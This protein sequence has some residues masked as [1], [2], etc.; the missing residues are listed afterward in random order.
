M[1]KRATS[2]L[3][4][5][6]SPVT[7]DNLHEWTA[8]LDRAVDKFADATANLSITLAKHSQR[9]DSG[10]KMIE[11]IQADHLRLE[12]KMDVNQKDMQSRLD[13]Q[14]ESVKAHFDETIKPLAKKVNVLNRWRWMIMGAITFIGTIAGILTW[15][16]E[17]L[18]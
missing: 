3:D 2:K 7:H 13:A 12:T 15:V 6:L 11:A 17:L 10:D 1:A 8:R 16:H 9:L 18:K 14:T 4:R 5:M